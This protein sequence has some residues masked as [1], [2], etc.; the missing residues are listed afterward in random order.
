MKEFPVHISLH[1]RMLVTVA[2]SPEGRQDRLHMTKQNF[3]P[4]I[5]STNQSK[6]QRNSRRDNK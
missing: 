4:L 6:Y 5:Y 2:T 1:G 3:F